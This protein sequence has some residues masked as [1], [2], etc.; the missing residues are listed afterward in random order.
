LSKADVLIE[1]MTL[2]QQV[3]VERKNRIEPGE[4]RPHQILTV[5]LWLE[6]D[7]SKRL[8]HGVKHADD[9]G[10]QVVELLPDSPARASAVLQLQLG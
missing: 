5:I 10:L 6:F 1:V 2:K 7:A 4:E 9:C 3:L 8:I